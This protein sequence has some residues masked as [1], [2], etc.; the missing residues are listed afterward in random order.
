MVTMSFISR[1]HS[2]EMT[3]IAVRQHTRRDFGGSFGEVVPSSSAKN[4]ARRIPGKREPVCG[5]LK[6][7][8]CQCTKQWNGK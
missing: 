7:S 8:I 2:S 6:A 4:L 5:D 1:M 3:D